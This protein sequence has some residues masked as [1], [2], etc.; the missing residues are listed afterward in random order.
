MKGVREDGQ[1]ACNKAVE[2]TSAVDGAMRDWLVIARAVEMYHALRS[3]SQKKQF[4]MACLDS[5]TDCHVACSGAA[6]VR[7]SSLVTIP[8]GGH[9]LRA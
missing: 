5:F 1:W 9:L 2:E 8:A 6:Q 3:S 4:R 7:S